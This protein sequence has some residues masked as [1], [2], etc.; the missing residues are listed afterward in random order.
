MR[1][2]QL[3]LFAVLAAIL[4]WI[5]ASADAQRLS[6]YPGGLPIQFANIPEGYVA[7]SDTTNVNISL[8][9]KRATWQS[10]RAQDFS[11][12]IDLSGAQIGVMEYEVIARTNRTDVRIAH[13]SPSRLLV[14]IEPIET[15]QVP[16]DVR[17]VGNAADGFASSEVK[18]EPSSVMVRGPRSAL[19]AIEH[20]DAKVELAGQRESFDVSVPITIPG[21]STKQQLAATP[22]AV[23]LHVVLGRAGTS[24]TVGVIVPTEGTPPNGQTITSLTVTPS[25]VSVTGSPQLLAQLENLSTESLILDT[26]EGET[27]AQLRIVLPDGVHFVDPAGDIVSVA[28]RISD[29]IARRII[30]VPVKITDIPSQLRLLSTSP[31]TIQVT[32]SGP[33]GILQNLAP[34]A[35]ALQLSAATLGQGQNIFQILPSL[36]T[37]HDQ[38]LVEQV[39]PTSVSIILNA[40]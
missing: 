29:V 11:A 34:D 26:I 20:V 21:G 18:S 28:V 30:T 4:F 3:K 14:R 33:V 22:E 16:V 31:S 13:T 9:A 17:V 32:I 10:L 8:V 39:L 6:T 35:I 15:K 23:M 1:H 19:E 40:Q 5:I 38:I 12:V 37:H 7:S 27:T 2:W 24:K 25:V 36:L